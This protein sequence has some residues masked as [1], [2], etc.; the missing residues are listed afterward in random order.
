MRATNWMTSARCTAI[1]IAECLHAAYSG[2]ARAIPATF[3]KAAACCGATKMSTRRRNKARVSA[4]SSSVAEEDE[5]EP[6]DGTVDR[7]QRRRATMFSAIG[8]HMRWLRSVAV[9]ESYMPSMWR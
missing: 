3:G 7:D 2:R 1:A 9:A 5:S 6:R 4:A 8:K